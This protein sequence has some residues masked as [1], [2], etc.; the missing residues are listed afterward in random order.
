MLL[1][2][3][4]ERCVDAEAQLDLDG[5]LAHVFDRVLDHNLALVQLDA[6]LSL[7]RVG[8]FLAGDRAEQTAR[9]AALGVDGQ[10]HFPQLRGQCGGFLARLS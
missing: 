3:Y 4:L 2:F 6:L 8:N 5:I 9:A 1:D 7:Q 10:R